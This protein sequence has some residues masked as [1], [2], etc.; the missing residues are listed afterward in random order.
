[1]GNNP[2]VADNRLGKIRA[3]A[4]KLAS[5]R[6]V[7]GL[8]RIAPGLPG[9]LWPVLSSCSLPGPA[10]AKPDSVTQRRPSR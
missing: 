7:Q 2:A 4:S 8:L 6:L 10:S 3:A 9:P 5:L 1:M